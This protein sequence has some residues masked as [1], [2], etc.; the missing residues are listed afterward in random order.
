MNSKKKKWEIHILKSHLVI[1]CATI[2]YEMN[3]YNDDTSTSCRL[4][5]WPNLNQSYSQTCYHFFHNDVLYCWVLLLF[6][7]PPY[8]KFTSDQTSKM[9]RPAWAQQLTMSTVC[10]EQSPQTRKV[11]DPS[12]RQYC[13]K[14]LIKTLREITDV[15]HDGVDATLKTGCQKLWLTVN[16]TKRNSP[17]LHLQTLRWTQEEAAA[18][19]QHIGWGSALSNIP[20]LTTHLRAKV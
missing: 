6:C 2:R 18:T 20:I 14:T 5:V 4:K 12:H 19:Q 7:P 13:Q 16:E 17:K 8:K 1:F 3:K 11:L 9:I 15:N 10:D